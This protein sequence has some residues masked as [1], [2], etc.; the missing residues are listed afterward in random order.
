MK[1]KVLIQFSIGTILVI[2][3]LIAY[4]YEIS[5]G[6]VNRRDAGG[7]PLDFEDYELYQSSTIQAMLFVSGAAFLLRGAMI[8]RSLSKT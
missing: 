6:T 2:A 1:R 3:A 4:S 8:Q 5:P 7:G